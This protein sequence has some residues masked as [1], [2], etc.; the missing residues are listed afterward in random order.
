MNPPSTLARLSM[1][2]PAELSR[3]LDM[4]V[5]ERELPSRSQ[6]IA[7][8][9][10]P[11]ETS[12]GWSR[13]SPAAL[14]HEVDQPAHRLLGRDVA[15]H[16]VLDLLVG[17]VLRQAIGA[18]QVAVAADDVECAD[19]WADL[20]VADGAP[21]Y[22]LEPRRFRLLARE[23]AGLDHHFRHRLVHREALGPP[24]AQPVIAAVAGDEHEHAR[25][26]T[27]EHRARRRRLAA[28]GLAWAIARRLGARGVILH[29]DI[30]SPSNY[31]ATRHLYQWLKARGII[32][33]SGI[34]TRA[35]TA[36]IRKGGMPNAV[37]A[38]APL[39]KFEHA[40]NDVTLL[41]PDGGSEHVSL[42]SKEEVAMAILTKVS[43][44]RR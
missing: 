5:E 21:E 9:M 19:L 2:L 1:S 44:L 20:L 30:T 26:D 8:L 42:R 31:R 32:G 39:E 11:A 36:L 18:E 16:P 33:L 13:P 6:L 37:I 38:R 28:F 23:G 24:A 22:G 12:E 15:R 41:T 17:D 10:R 4:M 7:E 25:P 35:L 27:R 43:S 29:T 3:K 40:T 14:D 34:D